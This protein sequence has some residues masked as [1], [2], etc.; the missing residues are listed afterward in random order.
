VSS[1]SGSNGSVPPAIH[2]ED[3]SVTYRTSLEKKPTFRN[4][5]VR[6]GRRQRTIREIKAVKGVSLEIKR[7]SVVGI[8]GA[9]GAGKSTLVRT[10]AG[11]LPPTS[12]RIEVHGR[13]STLL[14]LGVGFNK[15][16]TGRQNVTLGGLAAGLSRE[17]LREKYD[18][19]VAFAE[20]EEFMDMPMRT[21]SSGMYGRLGFSVAVNMEPD[22]LLIDEALSVG[23]AR[24]RKKSANKMKELCGQAR[25]IVLVSHALGTISDLCDNAVWMHKGELQ[26]QGEPDTVIDAYTQ[27]LEVGEDALTME[28]M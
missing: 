3:V 28:D 19:I 8:M 11:I 24:F 5:V 16:L 23:D 15:D 12:G 4:T 27:F 1:L 6:M 2:V 18:D 13:V 22:I 17:Q 14:A 20:L 7:G 25:T 9:N 26:Q 10:M 21:Y